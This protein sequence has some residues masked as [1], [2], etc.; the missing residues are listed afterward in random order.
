[1]GISSHPPI[2]LT[3]EVQAHLQGLGINSL[4]AP[5]SV[6]FPGSAVLEPPCSLKWLIPDVSIEIGAFSYAV[7]GY[8]FATK[9]G[10]YCSIGEH[11]Q[12]GR[13]SHPLSFGST[14]PL[15]YQEIGS[16]LGTLEHPSVLGA[17]FNVSQPPT[18]L[19]ITTIRNDVYIGHGAF[20]MPGVTIGNG[21]VIGAMSVVTKDVPDYAI[22][23]GSP[24][25][26]V[27]MRFDELTIQALLESEW[28]QFSPSQLSG[29]DASMPGSLAAKA[30]E[31]QRLSII[32]YSPPLR[33]LFS[34]VPE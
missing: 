4:H 15:F 22:V 26:V 34:I 17:S 27:R 7:S 20:I 5:G 11:V 9:I 33:Q 10:R 23:A 24:A 16:V 18:D 28:W 12:V 21:A 32:P 6:A 3:K 30:L 25:K 19:K 1:M 2:L 29:V 14:S 31:L 8:F 13:H